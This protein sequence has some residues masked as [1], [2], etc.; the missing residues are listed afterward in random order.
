MGCVYEVCV[1]V[2]VYGCECVSICGVYG[3]CVWDGCVCV[4]VRGW[5]GCGFVLGCIIQVMLS[6]PSLR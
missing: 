1:W 6:P 2:C 4:F 3:V 5:G